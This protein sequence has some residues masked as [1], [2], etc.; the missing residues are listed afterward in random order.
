MKKKK[1]LLLQFLIFCILNISACRTAPVSES[2]FYFDTYITVTVYDSCDGKILDECMN[3]AE[4][5]DNLWNRN[6]ENSDIYRV[7]HSDRNTVSVDP[8]TVQLLK[9]AIKYAEMSDGLVDPAIGSVTSKWN[10]HDK[11]S[12]CPPD[13]EEIRALVPSVNYKNIVLSDDNGIKIKDNNTKLDLGFIAKG[14]IADKIKEYLIT[15]NV[16]SAIINLGGNILTV[17]EKENN[18]PFIIGIQKPFEKTGTP[19]TS[20]KI[21][22]R[23]VVSSGI[24]E[25]CCYYNSVCYHH[26]INPRTGFPENNDLLGVTVISEKSVD[27]DA[28]STLCMLLGYDEADKLIHKIPDTEAIFIKKN[29]DIISTY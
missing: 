4:K 14:Y 9:I 25:R 13:P 18:E 2:G 10:F 8:E 17:G 6:K 11:E 22:D 15:Q 24:Y 19:V 20:V 12:F 5:Y 28:L 27:G 23:S 3:I 16:K 21:R 7:N 26:I 1:F 29:Y